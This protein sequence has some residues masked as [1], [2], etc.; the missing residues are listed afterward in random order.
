MN[1][2]PRTNSMKT[3]PKRAECHWAIPPTGYQRSAAGAPWRGPVRPL[4]SWI[5]HGRIPLLALLALAGS[6]TPLYAAMTVN[7][8][9]Q[10]GGWPASFAVPPGGGQYSTLVKAA[11]WAYGM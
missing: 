5:L 2:H 7:P 3:N 10:F 9:G 4:Q 1:N 11:G 6:R 8:A